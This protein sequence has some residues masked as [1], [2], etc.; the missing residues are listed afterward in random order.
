MN[1]SYVSQAPSEVDAC[2]ALAL[3]VLH[4][5]F[6]DATAGPSEWN[7]TRSR[8]DVESARCFLLHDGEWA[9]SRR[10]WCDHAGLAPEWLE[11]RIATLRAE[12]KL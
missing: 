6:L 4:Q 1:H 11:R 5:A 12:G 10:Y 3:A 2:Q 9:V 7:S 8:Q